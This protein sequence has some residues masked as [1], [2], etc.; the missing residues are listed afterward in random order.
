MRNYKSIFESIKLLNELSTNQSCVIQKPASPFDKI[1]SKISKSTN[2]G[3][4]L[5]IIDPDSYR[6]GLGSQENFIIKLKDQDLKIDQ[7]IFKHISENNVNGK[8]GAFTST[9]LNKKEEHYYRLIIPLKTKADFTFCI[10]NTTYRIKRAIS[11]ECITLKL[12]NHTFDFYQYSE[13]GG[14]DYLLIDSSSTFN[15][16]N[17]SKHCFSII[18][19]FGFVTGYLI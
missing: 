11:A 16:E 14:G 5:Q 10:D 9:N 15:L 8:I 3:Y 12:N 19:S 17:F 4:G 18:V 7:L 1:I 13:K 2:K 6:R